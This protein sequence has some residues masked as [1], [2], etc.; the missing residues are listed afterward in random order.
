[1][2]HH[3][4]PNTIIEENCFLY[5]YNFCFSWKAPV[6]L[7]WLHGV[8]IL[9]I[10]LFVGNFLVV[11]SKCL[12]LVQLEIKTNYLLVLADLKYVR[13]CL[14]LLR[15]TKVP[16]SICF[17][18]FPCSQQLQCHTKNHFSPKSSASLMLF[19]KCSLHTSFWVLFPTFYLSCSIL[20][21]LGL[22][23]FFVRGGLDC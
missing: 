6:I 19:E 8:T 1:M 16:F 14:Q 9:Q 15:C 12:K 22:L 21:F 4:K 3:N 10:Y 7:S 13:L 2:K 18:Y 17:P 20:F 23:G 5:F 11:S